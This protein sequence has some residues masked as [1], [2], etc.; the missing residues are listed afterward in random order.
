MASVTAFNDIQI[1][2][3]P[4]DTAVLAASECRSPLAARWSCLAVW[5][6]NPAEALM[7]HCVQ[8]DTLLFADIHSLLAD[9][10]MEQ[11]NFESAL[12]D[13]KRALQLLD[14]ILKV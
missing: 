5:Q 10:G 14:G 8:R 3:H 9:I 13:H 2:M 4:I 12:Q 11:E 6:H 7:L 1:H